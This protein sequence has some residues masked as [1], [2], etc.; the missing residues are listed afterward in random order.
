MKAAA[1]QNH[2]TFE[3]AASHAT[4]LVPVAAAN[5]SI[6]HVRLQLQDGRYECASHIIVCD[7]DRFCGVLTIEDV[8]AAPGHALARLGG[9]LT[10]TSTAR[11][12]SEE[13]T[14]RRFR[15]RLPWLAVGLAGALLAADIVGSFESQ[16]E[17]SILIAFFMPGIVYL[18]DAVGTQ[19]ETIVVRGLSLGV[20]LRR[21][22][23]R[24]LSIWIYLSIVTAAVT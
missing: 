6:S 5:E 15:H 21:M 20:P 24:V 12:T 14:P 16:L 7:G 1:D 11:A 9:F 2:F 13:P 4:R 8:L 22:L 3:A 19:T 10:D 17:T 23:S 18:A